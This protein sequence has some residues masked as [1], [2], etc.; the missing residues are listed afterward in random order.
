M[1]P[2]SASLKLVNWLAMGGFHTQEKKNTFSIPLGKG[3]SVYWSWTQVKDKSAFLSG[4]KWQGIWS[5]TEL[6]AGVAAGHE[7]KHMGI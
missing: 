5:I 1:V 2:F 4:P 7:Q 6:Y 3:K